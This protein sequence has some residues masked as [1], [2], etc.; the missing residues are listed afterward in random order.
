MHF[1]KWWVFYVKSF[2]LP[3]FEI[4]LKKTFFALWL[5][6][7]CVEATHKLKLYFISCASLYVKVTFLLYNIRLYLL[8]ILCTIKSFAVLI[9]LYS[10]CD[11]MLK[12]AFSMICLAWILM[13]QS[14][15]IFYCCS[16]SYFSFICFDLTYW[17]RGNLYVYRMLYL[18]A[19]S[20]FSSLRRL[21]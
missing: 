2:R 9:F 5:A 18:S 8:I 14:L 19:S 21:A 3:Y 15:A 1:M 17:I 16:S 11:F 12:S 13:H 20:S 4:A 6:K 7:S 10:I